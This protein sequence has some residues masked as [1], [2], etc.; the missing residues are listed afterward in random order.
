MVTLEALVRETFGCELEPSAHQLT[1]QDDRGTVA[2]VGVDRRSVGF[3]G[4]MALDVAAI[5]FVVVREDCRSDYV[6]LN[7]MA[8][9]RRV[10]RD[11]GL[12]FAMAFTDVPE[13]FAACGYLIVRP[14]AAVL[15]LGGASWPAGDWQTIGPEW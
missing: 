12:P 8:A 4:G 13:F 5:R 9:A 6:G 11:M 10:V 15:P 7:M 1:R 2:H 14:R 3:E